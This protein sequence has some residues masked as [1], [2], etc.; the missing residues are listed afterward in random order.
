[1]DANSEERRVA[2]SCREDRDCLRVFERPRVGVACGDELSGALRTLCS[3]IAARVESRRDESMSAKL[4]GAPSR[5]EEP[6]RCAEKCGH[7]G[8]DVF[9][10]YI[11]NSLQI[12]RYVS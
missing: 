12:C 8:G 5:D 6:L 4:K 3:M 9:L 2:E 10:S 11:I 1:M 7:S